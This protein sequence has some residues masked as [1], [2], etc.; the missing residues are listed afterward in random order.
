[1]MRGSRAPR[2]WCREPGRVA[3]L[4]LNRCAFGYAAQCPFAKSWGWQL[5]AIW[6]SETV[7][8]QVDR[9]Q[10][11][12]CLEDLGQRLES[13]ARHCQVVLRKCERRPRRGLM[14]GSGSGLDTGLLPPDAEG[15]ITS[16]AVSAGVHQVPTRTEVAVDD[17]VRR[18]EAL[19]VLW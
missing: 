14:V 13:F 9:G 7:E 16:S 2:K 3:R 5:A 4:P 17:R 15:L 1:M 18:E 11:D 8:H 12:H 19:G 10:G 6:M